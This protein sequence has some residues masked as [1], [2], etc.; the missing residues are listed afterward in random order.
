MVQLTHHNKKM[1]APTVRKHLTSLTVFFLRNRNQRD[2]QAEEDLF[3]SA[4][5]STKD[6]DH[7]V[8]KED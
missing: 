3:C 8:K 5:V 1:K 2:Y 6:W 4:P 7:F